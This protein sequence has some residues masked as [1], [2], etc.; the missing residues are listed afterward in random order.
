MTKKLNHNLKI[1]HR[2]PSKKGILKLSQKLSKVAEIKIGL[3]LQK[4]KTS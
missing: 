3:P 2:R 4:W 1:K